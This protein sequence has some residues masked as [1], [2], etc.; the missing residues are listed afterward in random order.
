MTALPNVDR[1]QVEDS[2]ELVRIVNDLQRRLA[3]LEVAAKMSRRNE[4][5]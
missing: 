4:A 2:S 1:E 5:T 3:A